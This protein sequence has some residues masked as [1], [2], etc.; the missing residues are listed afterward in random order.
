MNITKTY[1]RSPFGVL[2][3]VF[4]GKKLTELNIDKFEDV[5]CSAQKLK[6]FQANAMKQLKEYFE[7]KRQVFDMPILFN[8]GTEFEQSIWSALLEIPFGKRCSYSD[9]ACKIGKDAKSS[10]AVGR[11][12]GQ[13]PIAIIVPCHRVL[14]KKGNL[15]GFAW[16]LDRKSFLLHHEQGY[17]SGVQGELF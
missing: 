17:T 6:P 1:Y 3:F 2:E 4:L 14:G 7:G 5:D 16:G 13:N 8:K 10:R 15:T 11:A 12:V 9:V